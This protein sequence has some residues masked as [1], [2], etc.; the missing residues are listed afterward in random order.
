MNQQMQQEYKVH[1]EV[2]AQ[3]LIGLSSSSIPKWW[4]IFQNLNPYLDH[5][6]NNN[7]SFVG[8]LSMDYVTSTQD[9][10]KR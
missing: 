8:R 6:K 10:V 4:V 9:V 1:L 2:A 3:G 5:P 7:K